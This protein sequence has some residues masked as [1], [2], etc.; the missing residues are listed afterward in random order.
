M[1]NVNAVLS[2]TDRP[3]SQTDKP[4]NS[5]RILYKY[6]KAEHALS[7]IQ[8]HELKVSALCE[9][10]DPYEML[11]CF[12]DREG[13]EYPASLARERLV[14]RFGSTSGLICMSATPDDP[15][16]WAHY[17]DCHRGMAF[18]LQF[19]T[20][21][22]ERDVVP[23]TYEDTRIKCVL[24]DVEDAHKTGNKEFFRNQFKRLIAQKF[25]S[26]S[27]EQEYR[28]LVPCDEWAES[29]NGR[30]FVTLPRELFH[31]VILGCD[32]AVEE[33]EVRR[34]LVSAGYEGVRVVRAGLSDAGFRMEVPAS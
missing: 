1:P 16:V 3:A 14:K 30:W 34:M 21:M 17:A 22:L 29:R 4:H 18:A 13:R 9:L 6:M 33:A 19:S 8:S 10:N 2:G 32:C 11:P 27:Y 20:E 23:V 12:M 5:G 25:T 28:F 15:V 31:G 24:E 7:S 26:W